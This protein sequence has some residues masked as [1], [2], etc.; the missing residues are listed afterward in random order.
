M[1][2]SL[3][4]ILLILYQKF[5]TITWNFLRRKANNDRNFL[6]IIKKWSKR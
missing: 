4:G 2:S 1:A 6:K 5:K 3:Y